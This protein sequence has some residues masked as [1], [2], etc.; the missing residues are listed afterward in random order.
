MSADPPGGPPEGPPRRR[1]VRHEL[2]GGSSGRGGKPSQT[3]RDARKRGPSSA[4][5][6]QRQLN[7]PYVRRTHQEGWRSRAAF[8][9]I[10]IDERFRV[11]RKGAGVIDLGAAPGGWTQV[12]LSRGAADVVGI[13]LLPV[14]P[15]AGAQMLQGD[16]LDPDM[17]ASVLEALGRAPDLVLSD[18]AANTTGHR[19]TDHLR[20]I[21]LAEAAADFALAHLSVRGAFVTKVFQGGG[22]GGLLTRL[23]QAFEDVRHLKPP[24]SRA[25]SPELFLVARGFRGAAD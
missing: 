23:K 16:F 20:T 14:E 12:A 5:W 11:L 25:E 7:D 21:A 1:R 22:E 17:A 18:M 9:L 6:I 4:A 13:D 3:V 8:K 15:V 2:E 19:A 10:E 24:S